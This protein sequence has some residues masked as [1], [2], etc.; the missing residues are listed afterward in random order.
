MNPD[1]YCGHCGFDL[2]GHLY[3]QRDFSERVFGPGLR[4]G[5]VIDHIRK[6]LVEIEAEPTDL[7]EW[8]DVILLALDGAWRSGA[9]PER[10]VAELDR[11]FT[12][13]KTRTWPD[14]R[15]VDPNKAIEHV[16]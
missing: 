2:I 15:T 7:E 12:K 16:R 3:A 9:S 13:N 6:E 14:W 8:I 4:T 1:N 11:K 5:G 10:I